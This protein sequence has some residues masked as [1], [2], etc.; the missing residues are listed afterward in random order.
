MKTKNLICFAI[1]ACSATPTHTGIIS[2]TKKITLT[3]GIFYAGVKYHQAGYDIQTMQENMIKDKDET[4]DAIAK[5]LRKQ[6]ATDN[7]TCKHTIELVESCTSTSHDKILDKAQLVM[8]DILQALSDHVKKFTD[9][10]K[11]E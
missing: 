6:C 2:L 11:K 10:E 5:K 9:T 4:C 8:I 1:L 3:S 7:K